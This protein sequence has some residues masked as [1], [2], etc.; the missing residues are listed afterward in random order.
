MTA[1]RRE[2]NEGR[3]SDFA[4]I[5]VCDHISNHLFL[6]K[7]SAGIPTPN[8]HVCAVFS[9]D[10]LR[11]KWL[12]GARVRTLVVRTFAGRPLQLQHRHASAPIQTTAEINFSK[13]GSI[14]INSEDFDQ[15]SQLYPHPRAYLPHRAARERPAG[16]KIWIARPCHSVEHVPNV[17]ASAWV[18]RAGW[19]VTL[20]YQIYHV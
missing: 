15:S 17:Q 12:R 11:T 13:G 16:T 5:L 3:T 6:S 2:E 8:V 14:R 9:P 18:L 10:E 7:K 4:I 20:F 1:A 19:Y